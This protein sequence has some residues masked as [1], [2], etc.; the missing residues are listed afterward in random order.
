MKRVEVPLQ[1]TGV[2]SVTV[3][4]HFSTDDARLLAEKVALCRILAT[5]DNSDAPD[6]EACMDYLEKCSDT[7]QAIAEQDWDSSKIIGVGGQWTVMA[8]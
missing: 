3:P 5:C 7:A 1:F 4:G 8:E 2:V 6:D